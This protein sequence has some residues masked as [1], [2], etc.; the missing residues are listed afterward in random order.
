MKRALLSVSDKKG[1]IELAKFLHNNGVEIISTGGTATA[2]RD[3]NIQVTEIKEITGFPEMLGGRVK[4]LHPNVHGAILARREDADQMEEIEDLKIGLIDVVVTNLYPFVQSTQTD[5]DNLDNALE[6]IDI[7]GVTLLRAAAKNFKDVIIL[8]DPDDYKR[9]MNE[10][11]D[12]ID[13]KWRAALAVKAFQHTA[14]YDSSIA[15]YLKSQ[16]IL[17]PDIPEFPDELSLTYRKVQELRYGENPHQKASFYREI[18]ETSG[19]LVNA[20]QL[21]GKALSFNNISDTDAALELLKE[22]DEPSVVAVKHKN[23]CAVA[24][25]DNIHEAYSKAYEAD[26]VSIYGG[27]V[28]LNREVDENTALELKKI[29]LEVIIAPK[30]SEISLEIL[31]KKKN[32]RLI[33]LPE[34]I[35]RDDRRSYG[36]SNVNGGILVQE[37]DR[38]LLDLQ[39]INYITERKPEKSEMDDLIFAWKVVKHVRSNAIVLAKNK[40]TVGIGPGQTSRVWALE[41]AIQHAQHELNGAVMASDAFFP[42]GDS[43]EMA[44]NEGIT[45]VIQPGGSVRDQESIDLCNKYG[46]AMVFTGIRHFKH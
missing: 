39:S 9:F 37:G 38:E 30:Y 25:S 43:I 34:I 33:E 20:R 10:F 17:N 32:L 28:A 35:K 13:S 29:F 4:T 44:H 14:A 45:A 5:P 36:I 46:M 7:G 26:P 31:K 19:T 40:V 18:N 1:I 8:S 27:I 24:S 16:Q 2:L 21:H 3:E 11:P 15:A 6:N 12:K 23:P 41:A 22:F 42:F